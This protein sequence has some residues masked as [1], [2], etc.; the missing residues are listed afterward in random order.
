MS[1]KENVTTINDNVYESNLSDGDAY[2]SEDA[3]P[4]LEEIKIV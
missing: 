3:T 4:S 2:T 1:L